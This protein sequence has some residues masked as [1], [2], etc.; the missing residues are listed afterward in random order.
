[1]RETQVRSLDRGSSSGEG[2]GN[3]PQYSCLGNPVDRGAWQATIHKL[4]RRVRHN[5]ATKQ[6]QQQKCANYY[7]VFSKSTIS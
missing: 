5:L 6:Q 7:S 1:M 3:L 4:S 2:N